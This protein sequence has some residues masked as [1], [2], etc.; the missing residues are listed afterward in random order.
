[1]RSP[2]QKLAR[3][4]A[5]ASILGTGFAAAAGLGTWLGWWCD[6]ALGIRP[7]GCTI[8]FGLVGGVAGF[9]FVTRMLAQIERGERRNG[10]GPPD[11]G[12]EAE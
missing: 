7:I 12:E 4:F 11:R 3:G 5:V 2:F 8:V 6:R 9:V 1:M 10:I